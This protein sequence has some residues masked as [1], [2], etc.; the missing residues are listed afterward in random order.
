MSTVYRNCQNHGQRLQEKGPH[1]LILREPEAR[2]LGTKT[3]APS[4]ATHVWEHRLPGLCKSRP[5]AKIAAFF[6]KKTT[7]RFSLARKR[8]MGVSGCQASSQTTFFHH[9]M[10]R[11]EARAGTYPPSSLHRTRAPP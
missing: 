9:H 3:R 5:K 10:R 4:V 6:L 2:P 7:A 11:L 8:A 1:A